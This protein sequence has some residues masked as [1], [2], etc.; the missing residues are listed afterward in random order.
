YDAD[1]TLQLPYKNDL[2]GRLHEPTFKHLVGPNV[3]AKMNLIRMQGNNAV[4][5]ATPLK[6][7]DRLPIVRELFHVMIWFATHYSLN[8]ESRPQPGRTFDDAAVPKPQPGAV[9]K[10][11]EQVQKLA[12]EVATKDKALA[13]EQKLSASLEAELIVLRAEV[14]AAKA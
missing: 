10:S 7:T 12:A 8:A 2:V 9:A 1:E 13:D 5:R 3:F 6:S 4:H 14:A 11:L